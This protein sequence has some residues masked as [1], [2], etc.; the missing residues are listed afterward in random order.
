[1]KNLYL[2]LAVL[3]L[4]SNPLLASTPWDSWKENAPET[5]AEITK[6]HRTAVA[7]ILSPWETTDFAVVEENALK[8]DRG[9]TSYKPY[10][11]G[12][13]INFLYEIPNLNE[14]SSLAIGPMF[15]GS[16]KKTH[17]EITAAM[18]TSQI[19]ENADICLSTL[20]N[21]G[22][23]KTEASSRGYKVKS[24]Y[25][26][27][28]D[29]PL[30]LIFRSYKLSQEAKRLQASIALKRNNE[31]TQPPTPVIEGSN[32]RERDGKDELIDPTA[33]KL[34]KAIPPH[35]NATDMALNIFDNARQRDPKAHYGLS[36]DFLKL[37]I[38]HYLNYMKSR[39]HKSFNDKE[40][41]GLYGNLLSAR[42]QTNTRGKSYSLKSQANKLHSFVSLNKELWNIN[43]PDVQ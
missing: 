41:L 21:A 14:F 2:F 9:E 11:M 19:S 35:L 10:F 31:D 24:H 8:F 18:S 13:F 28:K 16:L 27:P 12:H 3:T 20:I 25:L 43:I 39:D 42:L 17:P 23:I 1:M 7:L 38:S 22:Q 36:R 5:Q 30:D 37:A 34:V 32:K 29:S 33:E 40:F 4:L 26:I 15:I 6:L